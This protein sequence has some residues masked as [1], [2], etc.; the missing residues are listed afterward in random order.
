MVSLQLR[1]LSVVSNMC[2]DNEVQFNWIC[3]DNEIDLSISGLLKTQ[4]D[5]GCDDYYSD[6]FST[7]TVRETYS[8]T[9]DIDQNL[10]ARRYGMHPEFATRQGGLNIKF[11]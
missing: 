3:H 5:R 4:T 2:H 1:R 9:L 7:K 10:R 8:E 11:R 6:L